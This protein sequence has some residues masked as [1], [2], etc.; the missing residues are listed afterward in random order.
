MTAIHGGKAKHDTSDAHKIAVLLRG[1]MFPHA[2]GSPAARRATRDRLRRRM[3]LTQTRAELL[4]HGPNT[5]SPYN[6][7]ESGQKM[8]SK[9]HREG[10]AERFPEPAVQKSLEVDLALIDSY[11]QLRRDLALHRVTAAQHPSANTLCLLRTVP[12][13]GNILRLVRLYEIHA[14][15]RFPRVQAFV[16][17]GRLV[18]CAKASAGT[19]DGPSGATIGQAYLKRAFSEAA[20]LFLRNH[21]AGQN[22]LARLEKKHGQ[23]NALTVLAHTLARA[24]YRMLTPETAFDVDQCFKA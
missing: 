15:R 7:P 8:A 23:G 5:N 11:D 9:A 3:Y 18:T 19:R 6:R 4:T 17:Y 16:S 21:P 13:I 22:Y 1:G 14:I 2:S 12:G 24:I 10:V 20:V